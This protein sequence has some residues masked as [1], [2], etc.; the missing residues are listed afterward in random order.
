MRTANA[1][2]A[3]QPKQAMKRVALYV[4]CSTHEQDVTN[5][6]RELEAVAQRHSWEVVG[7]FSDEGVSGARDRRPAFD[8]LRR[9]IMRKEFDM[10]AAWS[11]DRLGRSLQNLLVFLGELQ[12]KNVDLYLHQQGLDTQTPAGRA[13]FQ[14]LGVFGE[15]ERFMIRDRIM[16]GLARARAA[17]QR[18]GPPRVTV[19]LPRARA[20][21]AEGKSLRQVATIMGLKAATLHRHI[22]ATNGH[23]PAPAGRQ[24]V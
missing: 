7:I 24:A 5:Q 4:R 3:Q 15:W 12:A 1:T 17:G 21:L 20:L 16:A 11:V 9:G 13:L 19:D 23:R 2:V 18:L 10:V 22:S 8:R 6:Q 14:M